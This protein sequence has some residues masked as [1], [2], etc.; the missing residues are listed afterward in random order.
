MRV[1][2]H[3]QREERLVRE[4]CSELVARGLVCKICLHR[5]LPVI[6]N[7][8]LHVCPVHKEPVQEVES[9]LVVRHWVKLLL[10]AVFDAY[11]RTLLLRH[12][13]SL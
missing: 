12:R 6:S 2:C 3:P 11:P 13:N 5:G 7:K 1:L 10:G 9:L 4:T 8:V